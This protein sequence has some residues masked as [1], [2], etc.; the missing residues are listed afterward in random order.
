MCLKWQN[1][2]MGLFGST[3]VYHDV[4]KNPRLGR[5]DPTSIEDGL[6]DAALIRKYIR[7]QKQTKASAPGR[8]AP[9]I[10]REV[11]LKVWEAPRTAFHDE[12]L[13]SFAVKPAFRK[14]LLWIPWSIEAAERWDETRTVA[15]LVL[16]HVTPIDWMWRHLTDWDDDFE[17]PTSDVHPSPGWGQ[18]SPVWEDWAA[19]YLNDVWTVAVVTQKQATAIDLHGSRTTGCNSNPFTRYRMAEQAM[20]EARAKGEPVPPFSTAKFVLPG[21]A[22][23]FA[24]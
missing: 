9:A 15:G 21:H 20:N 17:D 1:H 23:D 8:P 16:E 18:P 19:G 4:Y 11:L 13:K 3:P 14:K 2:E 12:A 7:L 24:R 6:R 5:L 22:N 10:A